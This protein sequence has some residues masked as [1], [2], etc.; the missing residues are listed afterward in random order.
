[1]QKPLNY[2]LSPLAAAGSKPD[3]GF[4]GLISLHPMPGWCWSD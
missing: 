4:P 3:P 2:K 1:M